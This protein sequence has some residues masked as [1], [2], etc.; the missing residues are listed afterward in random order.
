MFYSHHENF[1]RELKQIILIHLRIFELL[2]P[3]QLSNFG[4]KMSKD[5][6]KTSSKIN[7]A[8]SFFFNFLFHRI[9]YL[10]SRKLLINRFFL[11][12]GF[13]TPVFLMNSICHPEVYRGKRGFF[14]KEKVHQKPP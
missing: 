6:G 9:F 8:I 3:V 14:F 1:N 5:S 11:L 4:I 2:M 13:E 12:P 10:P 7:V